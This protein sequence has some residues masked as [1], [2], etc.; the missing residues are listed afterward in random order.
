MPRSATPPLHEIELLSETKGWGYA[1]SKFHPADE[2]KYTVKFKNETNRKLYLVWLDYEGESV[3]VSE[4]IKPGGS[5]KE[6]T[7]LTY[8]YMARDSSS[9]S[10]RMFVS[11]S[12]K[13]TIFEGLKFGASPSSTV[14]I[15]ILK[16]D[17]DSEKGLSNGLI[18]NLATVL[19]LFFEH[20]L[21]EQYV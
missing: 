10:G 6:D 5:F 17:D 8:P 14:F 20:F 3:K 9:W 1:R 15:S 19:Y 18:S 11:R 4:N 21:T 12:T 2:I 16:I 13:S 7:Y